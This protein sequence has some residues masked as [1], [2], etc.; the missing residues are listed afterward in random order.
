MTMEEAYTV[1]KILLK[2]GYRIPQDIAVCSY[3]DGEILKY[4]TPS[5]TSIYD[6]TKEIGFSGTEK[7]IEL[8]RIGR[9]NAVTIVPGRIEYRES[10][11]CHTKRT[12]SQFDN[13]LKELGKQKEGM[14]VD[15]R[16]TEEIQHML[17]TAYKRTEF[18]DVLSFGLS[19]LDVRDCYMFEYEYS[20]ISR[21]FADCTLTY[22]FTES[23]HD[24]LESVD[25]LRTVK[26]RLLM[27]VG[28]SSLEIHS[29]LRS[30]HYVRNCGGWV[31]A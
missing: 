15:F 8:I 29:T 9:I 19:R 3:E 6:P 24:P 20:Y 21:D 17:A 11:G 4:A 26:H 10:C 31:S 30:Q 18:F 23:K 1:Q 28:I 16:Q 12:L 5:I 2:R 7:L 27:V 22:Q 25:S 14:D 13:E